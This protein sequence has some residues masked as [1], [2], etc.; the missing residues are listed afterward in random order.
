MALMAT[1]EITIKCRNG[2]RLRF[3]ERSDSAPDVGELVQTADGGKDRY[4]PPNTAKGRSCS[5]LFP[6][7]RDRNINSLRITPAASRRRGWSKTPTTRAFIV[8]D[9]N[10]RAL[11]TF[12]F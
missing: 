8:K 12:C 4:L 7:E 9:R 1:W 5:R 10:G 2:S 11:A 6:R 3:S